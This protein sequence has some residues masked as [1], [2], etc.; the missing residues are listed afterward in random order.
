[1]YYGLNV[2]TV[3]LPPL[4]A[5]GD[6][7]L[8]LARHFLEVYA[9]KYARPVKSLAPEA[10]ACLMRE[11]WVGNVRELAHVIERATLMADG[12]VIEA[13]H[14]RL[15]PPVEPPA[16]LGAQASFAAQ[17]ASLGG[18]TAPLGASIASRAPL[19]LEAAERQLIQQALADEHGNVSRA[20]RR[21]GVSRELLR[22]RA[23]KHGLR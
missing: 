23:R 13:H 16:S 7:V 20:A 14:L 17:P 12:E 4:R 1:L 11:R 9:R 18:Q 10:V 21:L 19:G 22:Y 15:A 6:D 2:L 5:R 8:L 3:T